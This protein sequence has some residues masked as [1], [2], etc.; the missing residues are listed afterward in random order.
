MCIAVY[1]GADRELPLASEVNGE[2]TTFHVEVAK[3]TTKF[4]HILANPYIY[5]AGSFEGYGCG[6]RYDSRDQLEQELSQTNDPED[7]ELI[8]NEWFQQQKS[9]EYLSK[10]L[11]EAVINGPVYVYITWEGE[12]GSPLRYQQS[13][14]PDYFGGECFQIEEHGLLKVVRANDHPIGD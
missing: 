9:V 11:T 7:Y 5:Y 1:I 8:E 14:T 12:E 10:Y 13:I 3:K 2:Y 4:Q 6:F